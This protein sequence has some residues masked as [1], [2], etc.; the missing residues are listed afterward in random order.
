VYN[1]GRFLEAALSSLLAQDHPSFEVVVSDNGSQDETTHICQAFA[2]RDRRVRFYSH[3]V[4]RGAV[5][6][7]NF[8]LQQARG[9]Y[10]MWAAHDDYWHPNCLRIYASALE[11]DR[12]AV[13]VCGRYQPVGS[14]D[15]P[16]PGPLYL[17]GG[18]ANDA[19]SARQRFCQMLSHWEWHGAIYGMYRTAAL[20]GV[21]P[22]QGIVACEV[23]LLTEIALAGK[24]IEVSEVCG[25]RRVPDPGVAY[26]SAAEQLEYYVASTRTA[27]RPIFSRFRVVR[28]VAR[29]VAHSQFSPS[30]K[31]QLG[32]DIA[33]IYATRLLST[34]VISAGAALL[35][36]YPSTLA[37]LRQAKRASTALA[38]AAVRSTMPLVCQPQTKGTRDDLSLF[39]G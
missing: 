13:L 17:S 32:C 2:S 26:R 27:R 4:N 3:P 9:Q 16:A 38:R 15:R 25:K 1:G 19:A 22:L 14:D 8:V 29:S 7:F 23:V 33:R 28:E 37:R 5:W 21:R 6:N 20:K 24:T 30:T 10:F 18:F 35:A 31:L 12:D 34:D 39:H 11:A 36:P